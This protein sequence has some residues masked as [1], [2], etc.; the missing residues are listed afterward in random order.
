MI[1][2]LGIVH[3]FFFIFLKFFFKVFLFIFLF[4]VFLCIFVCGRMSGWVW[5][6]ERE[7]DVFIE[8]SVVV[9]GGERD[10]LMIYVNENNFSQ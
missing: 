10:S 8:V 5:R 7:R 1:N 6:S 4:L 2:I 9:G 3:V